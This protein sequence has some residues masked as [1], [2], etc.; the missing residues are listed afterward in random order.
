MTRKL[1]TLTLAL[2]VTL[3]PAAIAKADCG[4]CGSSHSHEASAKAASVK[5]DIVDT[6]VAA[7]SFKTLAAALQ[8]A[9]LVEALKG[10]EVVLSGAEK[11]R[12]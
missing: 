6:A 9:D 5:A 10:W 4:G 3:V 11:P 7:G 2:F 1:M 12:L 8:A